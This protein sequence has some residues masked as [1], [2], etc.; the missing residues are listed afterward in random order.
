MAN[1]AWIVVALVG[2][3]G[4]S[5]SNDTKDGGTGDAGGGGDSGS[6]LK[7][8]ADLCTTFTDDTSM[9]DVMIQDWHP[10]LSMTD[11]CIKIKA[12]SKVTWPASDNHPIIQLALSDGSPNNPIPATAT[13]MMTDV[14]FPTAG[15]YGYWCSVHKTS[16]QGVI[17]VVP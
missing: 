17:Q 13:A 1:R 12:G 4:C 11:G 3:L 9:T 5:S 6:G 8:V 15:M 10:T 14:T 7:A 2:A 16:M